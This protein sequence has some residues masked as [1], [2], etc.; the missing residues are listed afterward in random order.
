LREKWMEIMLPADFPQVELIA[1]DQSRAA[2]TLHGAHVVSWKTSDGHERLFMSTRT[3]Y[4]ASTALR[5]GVPVVFP[6]FSGLGPLPKHGFARNNI[7]EFIGSSDEGIG[8]NTAGFRLNASHETRRIWDY[9]FQLDLA[10]TV[11]RSRL[12][13]DFDV[14]NLD[15]PPFQFTAALHTYLRVQDISQVQVEGLEGMGYREYDFNSAQPLTPLRIVGEVDRIYWNVPGP[16]IV[17]EGSQAVQVMSSGF[18]DVVVWNP[19][20]EKAAALPDMEPEGYR[21]ML[22]IEAAV[23]GQPVTLAPGATWRGTQQISLISP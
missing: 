8:T 9:A 11:G 6:Q 15:I 3:D 10:M 22:C 12:V 21:R 13:V 20:P 7:W 14:T 18:P 1:P 5:G 23:I 16:L 17:R 19:G 4:R 2:I